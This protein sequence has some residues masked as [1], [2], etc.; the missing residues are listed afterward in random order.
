MTYK[1]EF[2]SELII[3]LVI[4][5]LL[6]IASV[7]PKIQSNLIELINSPIHY[8]SMFIGCRIANYRNDPA[9]I[10]HIGD[11]VMFSVTVLY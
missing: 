6:T 1:K 10:N 3:A 2:T 9:H 8:I 11:F 7:S 5:A 4:E